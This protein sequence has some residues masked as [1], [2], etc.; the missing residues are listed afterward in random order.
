[1]EKKNC[2]VC[3]ELIH[4]SAKKCIHCDSFQGRRRLLNLSSNVLGLMVGLIAVLSFFLPILKDFITP[5]NS[6]LKI[7]FHQYENHT[8]YFIVTN[9][10]IRPGVIS[11]PILK[12][13]TNDK[14]DWF[15][16]VKSI[17]LETKIITKDSSNLLL[18]PPNS[19]RI[20]SIG[21]GQ[22]EFDKLTYFNRK[23]DTL[24]LRLDGFVD[25]VGWIKNGEIIL[26]TADFRGKEERSIFKIDKKTVEEFYYKKTMKAYIKAD[27]MKRARQ[28]R[29]YPDL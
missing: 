5:D 7:K 11:K 18:V 2:V 12:L 25:K 24:T 26:K 8:F 19:T 10:G 14:N 20:F 13:N 23:K 6:S 28:N 22:Y 3:G 27:S 21:N 1:M 4:I 29:N 15:A 9:S 16:R 17:D